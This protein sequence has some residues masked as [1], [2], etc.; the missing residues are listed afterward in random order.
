LKNACIITALLL[1]LS[2][3]AFAGVTPDPTQFFKPGGIGITMPKDTKVTFEDGLWSAGSDKSDIW[4]TF[5]QTDKAF[6]LKDLNEKSL[7]GFAD[8]AEAEDFSFSGSYGDDDL[9]YVYGTAKFTDEDGNNA[10][11]YIGLLVNKSI[12][13]KSF[14]FT[15][16]VPSMAKEPGKGNADGVLESIQ[17]ASGN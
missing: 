2:P 3:S 7:K 16:L 4:V 9:S 13:K 6:G 1:C 17:A 15:I 11:G 5:E 14:V 8:L 12:A 10:E